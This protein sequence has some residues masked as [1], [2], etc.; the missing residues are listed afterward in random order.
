MSNTS[1][2]MRMDNYI[3]FSWLN[4]FFFCPVSIYF[5][6]L[7]GDKETILTQTLA[8][9]NGTNAHRAVDEER[10]SSRKDVLQATF[11]ICEKYGLV[12]RIDVFDV[13]SGVLTERKKKVSKVFDGQV[14]QIY[15]QYFSL[16]EMGYG[17]QQ[18]R[19]HSLSDN[20]NYRIP[21]PY[22]NPEMLIK[23]EG[24]VGEIKKFKLG[25]YVPQSKAKCQNCIYEP[26]CD[27]SLL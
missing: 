5:H 13:K 9:I 2:V 24:L 14:F 11:V 25:D 19:L 21:L 10:Y 7:Y 8:Q 23:F 22:E 6:Q 20:K 3:L 27:R 26:V 15:A 1:K 17:V 12:G 18:L 16:E 4:D